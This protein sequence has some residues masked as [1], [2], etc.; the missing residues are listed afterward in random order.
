MSIGCCLFKE[1]VNHINGKA[2]A[3]P[4]KK[5]YQSRKK[6]RAGDTGKAPDPAL[7]PNLAAEKNR[8]RHC[9]LIAYG[10]FHRFHTADRFREGR[11][12]DVFR[13]G[14]TATAAL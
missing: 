9:R 2:H 3:V 10:C 13:N 12:L 14:N 11:I 1:T 4:I 8:I 7:N 6:R 5:E